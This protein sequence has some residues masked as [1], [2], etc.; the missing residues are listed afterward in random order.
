V[1][2]VEHL[3]LTINFSLPGDAESPDMILVAKAS[4]FFFLT[5]AMIDICFLVLVG[6]FGE[7]SSKAEVVSRF[8]SSFDLREAAA[9]WSSQVET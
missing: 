5:K 2:S 8:W 4:S 3:P 7:L 1:V 6:V 9:V